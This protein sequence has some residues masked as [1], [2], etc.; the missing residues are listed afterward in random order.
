MQQMKLLQ[1]CP[2][3]GT[4]HRAHAMEAVGVHVGREALTC[5][6]SLFGRALIYDTIWIRYGSLTST[7]KLKE[8]N[9]WHCCWNRR[10]WLLEYFTR[11]IEL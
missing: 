2:Y 10:Y 4:A 5:L 7:E 8:I 6:V 1:T 11:L 3:R 9:T